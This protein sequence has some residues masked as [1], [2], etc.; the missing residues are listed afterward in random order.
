MPNAD[1]VMASMPNADAVDAYLCYHALEAVVDEAVND[2]VLK[3][4][5]VRCTRVS[6]VTASIT[7]GAVGRCTCM[8]MSMCMCVCA[9]PVRSHRDAA[10]EAQREVAAGGQRLRSCPEPQA[11]DHAA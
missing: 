7:R 11:L 6:D 3:Q 4:V 1:T 10:H 5:T 8:R 9:G 2:A